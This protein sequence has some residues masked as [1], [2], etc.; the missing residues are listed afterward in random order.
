MFASTTDQ[1]VFLH[2]PKNAGTSVHR[3]LKSAHQTND[4]V[5]EGWGI[6]KG[7]DLA[8]PTPQI[9]NQ[10]YPQDYSLLQ[11]PGTTSFAILR[12]P[13]A[14]CLSAFA[15]H[16]KQYGTH[17][18]ASRTLSEYLDRIESR[19]YLADDGNSYLF[20]HGAPQVEFIYEDG[21]LLPK[22]LFR[23]ED[24]Q[25]FKRLCLLLGRSLPV[26]HLN[27]SR[28]APAPFLSRHMINLIMTIYEQDYELLESLP[29]IP[30]INTR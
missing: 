3:A 2:I 15:E 19:A 21:K 10:Y 29:D 11:H 27:Q 12:D 26:L 23:M 4:Q 7:F 18:L 16:R 1:I 24:P 9:L 8:H 17:P 22:H 5:V 13:L 6:E 14:R 20:I 30:T 25:L 28:P